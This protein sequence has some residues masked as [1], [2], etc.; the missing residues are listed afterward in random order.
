MFNFWFFVNYIYNNSGFLL[1]YAFY[2][3]L[4]ETEGRASKRPLRILFKAII[5]RYLR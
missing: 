1:A 5:L 4:K 2:D 3:H